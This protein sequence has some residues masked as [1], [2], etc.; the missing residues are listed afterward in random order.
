MF[1]LLFSR[2]P[3]DNNFSSRKLYIKCDYNFC[4]TTN[5]EHGFSVHIWFFTCSRQAD[6]NLCV[7]QSIK[8]KQD[9]KVSA[10]D[11]SNLLLHRFEHLGYYVFFLLAWSNDLLSTV[12]WTSSIECLTFFLI[13]APIISIQTSHSPKPAVSHQITISQTTQLCK[14]EGVQM[15]LF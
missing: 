13:W 7:Q 12:F 8:Q 6:M 15:Q 1:S 2:Q 5:K 4:I 11:E 3:T 9:L 14:V 10:Y